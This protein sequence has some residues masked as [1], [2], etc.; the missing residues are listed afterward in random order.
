M[1]TTK[2]SRNTR[3]SKAPGS[4]SD[5]IRAAY[6]DYL[7]TNGKQPASVY[8][9]CIDLG[10]KEESF[11]SDFGS[12]DAI[13]KDIWTSFITKTSRA[14]QSDKAFATF[15]SRERILSFYYALLE[16]LKNNRSFVLQQIGTFRKPELTPSY[17]KGF[18][19]VFEDFITLALN[20]GKSN[21]EISTRPYI[22]KIYPQLFWMHFGF[23]VLYWRDDDS[24]GFEKTDAAVEKSVN[25]AFDL[26]GK[27]AIDSAFDFAKFLYQ[28]K[29]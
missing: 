22:D 5:K 14:L 24:A 28:S 23:I 12:F 7:L 2:K 1:E 8:K 17:L 15:T 16:E 10:I 4:T 18:K 29:K 20:Q 6:V 26:I 25:L 27:G 19:P 21:G 11:Y 9:F 13:E 3:G